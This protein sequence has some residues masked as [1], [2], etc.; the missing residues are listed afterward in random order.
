MIRRM[1]AA[2]T[3]G[4]LTAALVACAGDDGEIEVVVQSDEE[5]CASQWD[6]GNAPPD[7][8]RARLMRDCLD[9]LEIG[10]TR[11]SIASIYET[12]QAGG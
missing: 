5:W 8:D 3:A 1:V 4:V 12:M 7:W 9:G 2:L 6:E 10:F 11:E